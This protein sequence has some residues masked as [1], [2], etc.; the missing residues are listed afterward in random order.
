MTVAVLRAFDYVWDRLMA[1]IDGLGDE[2]YFWEP[3]PGGWSLRQ[4]ADGKWR[5]DGDGGGGP[6]PDPVP[7]T[8]IAWRLGHIAGTVGGFARMRFGDGTP[9]SAAELDVP[10]HAAQVRGFLTEHYMTW[11]QGLRGL[12][13]TAWH[14]PIGAAFGPYAT[15]DTSDLALHVL[16]EVV[17][18]GAE[19]GVLR[20]LWAAGVR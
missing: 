17:H 13:E 2:E 11:M 4:S 1:R 16:D 5:L 10:P 3:V 15:S 19:V 18:H 14:E 9:L 6:T 8:T 20:D 7:V 12:P